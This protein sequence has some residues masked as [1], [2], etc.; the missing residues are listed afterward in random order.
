MQKKKKGSDVLVLP[1][2]ST[3]HISSRYPDIY[4]EENT[5]ISEQVDKTAL[6]RN[7]KSKCEICILKER[8]I[9]VIIH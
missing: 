7:I 2:F 3:T 9:H 4:Q 1:W 8:F 6:N 5:G